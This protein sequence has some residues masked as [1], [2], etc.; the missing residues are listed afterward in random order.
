MEGKSTIVIKETCLATIMQG[1]IAHEVRRY[2]D[3]GFGLD[4]SL[5]P[6]KICKLVFILRNKVVD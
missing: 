4:L 5:K 2:I 1:M 3:N 6:R